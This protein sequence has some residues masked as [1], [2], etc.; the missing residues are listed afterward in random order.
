[1]MTADAYVTTASV[2]ELFVDHRYQR[3]L[4]EA[5]AK[6]MAAQWDR[7]MVGILDVS[8]RGSSA[9]PRYA[10]VDGQHRFAG[11]ALLDTPPIM[12]V[13]V[14]TGLSVAQEA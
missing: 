3:P 8:D 14:H 2:G 13:N 11:A 10:V 9:S 1:M 7:R 5:R 12:V 6:K 4:D